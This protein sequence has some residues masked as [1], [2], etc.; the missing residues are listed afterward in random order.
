MQNI[1]KIKLKKIK[2]I[3]TIFIDFICNL[4]LSEKKI[5]YLTVVYKY[6]NVFRTIRRNKY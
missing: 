1:V 5:N 6:H 2:I 4:K 3:K